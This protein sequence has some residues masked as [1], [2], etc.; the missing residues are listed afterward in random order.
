MATFEKIVLVVYNLAMSLLIK[1][2]SLE[3]NFFMSDEDD[4]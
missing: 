1:P 3:T 2:M 4:W